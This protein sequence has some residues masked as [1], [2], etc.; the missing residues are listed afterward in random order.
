MRNNVTSQVDDLKEFVRVHCTFFLYY[1]VVFATMCSVYGRHRDICGRL[2]CR[3]WW[4]MFMVGSD[5][6]VWCL[7][8]APVA[9]RDICGRLK[10]SLLVGNVHGRL[11]RQC[12]VFMDG[13]SGTA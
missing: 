5:V 1:R 3:C 9:L 11:W 2:K 12:V 10:V 7:W 6:N 8:T 4:L 13:A